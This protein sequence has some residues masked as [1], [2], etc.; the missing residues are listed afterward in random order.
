[1]SIYGN[2]TRLTKTKAGPDSNNSTVFSVIELVWKLGGLDSAD[3]TSAK[4]AVMLIRS[5]RT[6]P[7]R[8]K[9]Q[10]QV[11][12]ADLN[13]HRLDDLRERIA[14]GDYEAEP[15]ELAEILLPVL[16]GQH[17]LFVE[18]PPYEMLSKDYAFDHYKQYCHC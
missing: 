15:K 10:L 2:L 7:T 8:R 18:A 16:R 6:R 14:S 9:P 1:M 3:T 4:A 12:Q 5:T 11:S 17:P 13:L